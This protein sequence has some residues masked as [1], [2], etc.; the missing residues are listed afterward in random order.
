MIR[1][2]NDEDGDGRLEVTDVAGDEVYVEAAFHPRDGAA[3]IMSCSMG[4]YLSAGEARAF[5]QRLIELAD[6][7]EALA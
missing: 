7:R 1:D 3:H 2:Y 4:A 6:A 5:A